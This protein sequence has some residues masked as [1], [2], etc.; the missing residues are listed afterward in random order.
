M[1]ERAKIYYGTAAGNDF[2]IA[3]KYEVR[4]G[5][6]NYCTV[7]IKSELNP[8]CPTAISRGY[9][10]KIFWT[11]YLGYHSHREEWDTITSNKRPEDMIDQYFETYGKGIM[12]ITQDEIVTRK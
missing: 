12:W 8:D 11:S 6:G 4:T 10:Y 2:P 1:I 9:K 7:Y 3:P 5:K